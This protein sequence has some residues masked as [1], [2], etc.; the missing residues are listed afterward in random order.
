MLETVYAGSRTAIPAAI[1]GTWDIYSYDNMP[2][3]LNLYAFVWDI[4][5]VGDPPQNIPSTGGIPTNIQTLYRNYLIAGGAIFIHGE[6]GGASATRNAAIAA[7]VSLMGGG[8]V[9]S[10]SEVTVD[11]VTFKSQFVY[12]G[13]TN[14]PYQIQANGVFSSI[15]NGITLFNAPSTAAVIWPKG[16]MSVAPLGCLITHLDINTVDGQYSRTDFIQNLGAVLF[17]A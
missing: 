4:Y 11:T 6:H 3:D 7:F 1:G 13:Y 17:N 15:G 16:A 9:T 14:T 5:A 2:P 12:N 8:N 10:T